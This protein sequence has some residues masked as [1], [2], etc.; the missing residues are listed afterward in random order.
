MQK[1]R[2]SFLVFDRIYARQIGR[3]IENCS[4]YAAIT[5]CL[6]GHALMCLC[7]KTNQEGT[8]NLIRPTVATF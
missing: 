8:L 5:R 2:E 1:S 7:F 6:H 3:F 4:V